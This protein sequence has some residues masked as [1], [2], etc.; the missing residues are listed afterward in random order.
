MRHYRRDTDLDTRR[1]AAYN[2]GEM[3]K[4]A[5]IRKNLVAIVWLHP[6]LE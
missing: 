5:F 2:I 4:I 1:S 6:G 3:I